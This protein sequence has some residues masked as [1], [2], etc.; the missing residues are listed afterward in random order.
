MINATTHIPAGHASQ[1]TPMCRAFKSQKNAQQLGTPWN[2]APVGQT[3]AQ[4][5]STWAAM[6]SYMKFSDGVA[7]TS[8]RAAHER[9]QLALRSPDHSPPASPMIV[10]VSAL[11]FERAS[12]SAH[13]MSGGTLASST[14]TPTTESSELPIQSL[15][16]ANLRSF[17]TDGSFPP[18]KHSLGE[19][20][21]D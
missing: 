11:D 7:E 6:P 13:P 8:L 17:E 3:N 20:V 12:W 19:K 5:R 14:P 21:G 15:G 18:L 10:P 4:P 2:K 9:L 1:R 16:S